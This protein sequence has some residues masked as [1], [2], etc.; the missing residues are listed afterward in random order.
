MEIKFDQSQDF[1]V[2]EQTQDAF[3]TSFAN[4]QN[5]DINFD[6]E[7]IVDVGFTEDVSF[8]C[9]FD[10]GGDFDCCSNIPKGITHTIGI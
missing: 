2:G 4:E 6:S 9:Q 3:E 5:A 8:V 7:I 1:D 10:Q